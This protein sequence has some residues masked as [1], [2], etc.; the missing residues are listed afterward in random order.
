MSQILR[1][2]E[3]ELFDLLTTCF[4][5]DELR[6]FI[7]RNYGSVLSVALPGAE[8]SLLR[9]GEVVLELLAAHGHLNSQLKAALLAERPNHRARIEAIFAHWPE[10]PAEAVPNSALSPEA[11]ALVGRN[12]KQFVYVIHGEMH[13]TIREVRSFLE[14][15]GLAVVDHCSAHQ[16]LGRATAAVGEAKLAAVQGA[17]AIMVI[18]SEEDDRASLARPSSPSFSGRANLLFDAGLAFAL[19]P[20]R[21]LLVKVGRPALFDSV[22]ALKGL[23]AAAL[24]ETDEST[25]DL[26][27]RLK[28]LDCP[29]GTP[30][31]RPSGLPGSGAISW[32]KEAGETSV[33]VL[34][35]IRSRLPFPSLGGELEIADRVTLGDEVV[36]SLR[37]ERAIEMIELVHWGPGDATPARVQLP[38]TP[39]TRKPTVYTTRYRIQGSAGN[40]ILE[41]LVPRTDGAP[42]ESIARVAVIA[43]RSG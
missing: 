24:D 43:A 5:I 27:W 37:T 13:R 19:A 32:V 41:A 2:R 8:A 39:L 9:V 33:A 23:S 6:V 36:L 18:V 22:D 12:Q 21:T 11:P 25:E 34:R 20:K 29:I 35:R 17:K 26:I 15:L 1:P 7:L 30:R 38:T 10:A 14:Q 16:L 31:G 40:H 28:R 3:R 42:L 4:N